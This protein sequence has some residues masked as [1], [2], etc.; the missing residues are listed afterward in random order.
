MNIDEDE[1][2]EGLI[3][4]TE[5]QLDI[6]QD[7]TIPAGMMCPPGFMLTYTEFDTFQDF[8]DQSPWDV[9]NQQDFREI[10]G[11]EFDTY[12]RQNTEFQDWEHMQEV[13]GKEYV[14]RK[15]D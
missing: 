3:E 7:N 4:A 5:K 2:K 13:A 6:H 8:L 10:P 11:D 1:L 14:D 9:E 12:V 15:T